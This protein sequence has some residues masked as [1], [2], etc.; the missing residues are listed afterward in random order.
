MINGTVTAGTGG[1]CFVYTVWVRRAPGH[2]L[3]GVAPP[4]PLVVPGQPPPAAPLRVVELRQLME[5]AHQH[6][7]I[8]GQD[9]DEASSQAETH[10]R[11]EGAIYWKH[12]CEGSDYHA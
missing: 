5:P 10:K 9:D 7:H 3:A 1:V 11:P 6:I 8:T 4:P 2:G 12:V